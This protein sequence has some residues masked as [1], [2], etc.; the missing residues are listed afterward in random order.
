GWCPPVNAEAG[1]GSRW[2]RVGLTA[3]EYRRLL[4]LLGR[5]PNDLEL[6]MVGVMWSEH[7]SYKSSRAHLRRLPSRGPQV[8]MGPGENAGVLDLGDGEAVALRCES[9]NHPS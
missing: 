6:E 4:D 3:E 2:E 5:E 8:L 1:A 9:H 7:C